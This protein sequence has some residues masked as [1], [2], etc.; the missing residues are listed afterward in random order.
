MI[1]RILYLIFIIFLTNSK[2]VIAHSGY[3]QHVEDMM[4]VFGFK[5]N[6]DLRNWMRFISSDMIDKYQPFDAELQSRHKGF[7]CKHRLLFHWGYNA[8][9]WNKPLENKVCSY[10]EQRDLNIESNIRIFKSE[11]ISEQKKRNRT[12]NRKTELLFGFAHGGRDAVYAN[13]FASMAYNTHLI[14][15]YTSDNSDLDGLVPFNSL[16]GLIINDLRKFDY[17]TC[18]PLIK[19]IDRINKSYSN[20]QKKAD[21]LM[22]Y[23]KTN[24][25]LVIKNAQ[26]GSIKRRLE[27][28]G[29]YIIDS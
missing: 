24:M 6:A 21:T 3:Q 10:C 2:S 13:F 20:V 19:D 14:G 18:K 9:P 11:M 25:P 27:N 22:Q 5:E 8:E 7:S 12:L 17:L 1:K 28:K 16:I 26:G 15:D 23:L 4:K 29:F